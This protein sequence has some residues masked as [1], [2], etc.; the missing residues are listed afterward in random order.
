MPDH[1][2]SCGAN[3][4]IRLKPAQEVGSSPLVRGQ[5]P[6][7]FVTETGRRIIPARAGP[8]RHRRRPAAQALDHPRSCG[9]NLTPITSFRHWRGSSPLVRGQRQHVLIQSLG[10]RI[11]PARAGPT[12][13]AFISLSESSDHPRSCGANFNITDEKNG[14][15]GSSPLVRGQPERRRQ[16]HAGRRIIPARAGPTGCLSM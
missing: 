13:R 5:P 10:L 11:I 6:H 16:R 4:V 9:A 1:P 12:I 15:D 7:R 8:T 3:L 14:R 2:R